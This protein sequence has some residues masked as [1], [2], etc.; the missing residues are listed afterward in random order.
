MSATEFAFIRGVRVGLRG[1][2][3]QARAHSAALGAFALVT[4]VLLGVFL[5][6]LPI[7][8]SSGPTSAA[9][10]APSS[11]SAS[12][13]AVAAFGAAPV[14]ASSSCGANLNGSDIFCQ[15]WGLMSL[16]FNPVLTAIG[17]AFSTILGSFA[18]GISTMFQ[19]WGFALGTYG[20]WAPVFTVI[21]LGIAAFVGY[22]FMDLDGIEDDIGKAIDKIGGSD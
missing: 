16:L 17:A 6:A 22:Y 15:I 19:N 8:A 18:T 5:A 4:L 11:P 12:S 3:R 10:A 20:I 9:I 14:S 2:R 13:G 1:I 7:S 21:S